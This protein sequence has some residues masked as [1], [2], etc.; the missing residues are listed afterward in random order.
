MQGE[1]SQS[2]RRSSLENAMAP[3]FSGPSILG[4]LQHPATLSVWTAT[5][6]SQVTPVYPLLWQTNPDHMIK[7]AKFASGLGC[8]TSLIAPL[9]AIL[10]YPRAKWLFAFLLLGVAVLVLN[11]RLARD[12]TPEALADEIERLLTGRSAGW[13]VDNFESHRIRDPQLKELWRK[14]M[15]AGPHPAPE[16]WVGLDEAHK[17]RLREIIRELR[18]LGDARD[19]GQS[20][21]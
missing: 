8:L 3:I 11:V 20:E 7:A 1:A 21:P 19:A 5:I 4:Y 17:D 14:S 2:R 16:E 12:P 6:L 18:A 13:D 9:L 10:L 15:L